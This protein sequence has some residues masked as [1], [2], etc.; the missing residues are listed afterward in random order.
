M[1]RNQESADPHYVPGCFETKVMAEAL[2]SA[3]RKAYLIANSSEAF[4]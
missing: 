1:L 2:T 3:A 4:S